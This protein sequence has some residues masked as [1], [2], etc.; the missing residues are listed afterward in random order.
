LR[1]VYR[2]G[3]AISPKLEALL[4]PKFSV[5]EMLK[6]HRAFEQ[7]TKGQDKTAWDVKRLKTCIVKEHTLCLGSPL[8]AV[9]TALGVQLDPR[10]LGRN[11]Q[12]QQQP[13]DC[14]MS[15]SEAAGH[16]YALDLLLGTVIS[17]TFARDGLLES[18]PSVQAAWDQYF[19]CVKTLAFLLTVP[20]LVVSMHGGVPSNDGRTAHW[21]AVREAVHER[22]KQFTRHI[23]ESHD[24]F[25]GESY[26]RALEEAFAVPLAACLHGWSMEGLRAGEAG[27]T[28]LR[29]ASLTALL[30]LGSPAN[31]AE[32]MSN[33]RNRDLLSVRLIKMLATRGL[34]DAACDAI[35]ALAPESAN[36][37][38]RNSLTMA[39]FYELWSRFWSANAAAG[40]RLALRAALGV[41]LPHRAEV[42]RFDP[43]FSARCAILKKA[44]AELC[45][46]RQGAAEVEA[47]RSAMTG[48]ESTSLES[49][50]SIRASARELLDQAGC[51]GHEG[52]NDQQ[53]RNVLVSRCADGAL[54]SSQGRLLF[55]EV[56]LKL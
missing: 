40:I 10:L 3:L 55:I 12:V 11:G 24:K 15:L 49:I 16:I 13:S 28:G 23:R 27:R 17:A 46:R 33:S 19:R 56:R 29:Q 26:C 9:A 30:L 18:D 43:D 5:D 8:F 54:G 39:Q 14:R 34:F 1:A 21:S 32:F 2:H 37:R 31:L 45:M 42:D 36:A 22:L 7:Y 53:L 38:S 47:W 52:Q 4:G 48:Q 51:R 20:L 25:C 41:S 50:A 35:L 44:I 6:I